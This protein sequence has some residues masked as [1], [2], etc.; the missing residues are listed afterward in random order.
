MRRGICDAIS[1]GAEGVFLGHCGPPTTLRS[2]KNGD[3]KEKEEKY[4]TQEDVEGN[5]E[6]EKIN[7]IEQNRK[8]ITLSS[9]KPISSFPTEHTI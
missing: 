3:G 9:T 2:C 7:L 5:E 6:L 1:A 4:Q 8:K